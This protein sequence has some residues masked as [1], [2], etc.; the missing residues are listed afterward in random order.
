MSKL[1]GLPKKVQTAMG[2]ENLAKSENRGKTTGLPSGA[3]KI[4]LPPRTFLYTLDQISVMLDLPVRALKESHLYFEGRSTG[5]RKNDLM[6]CRNIAATGEKPEWRIAE[7]EFTRWMRTKGFRFYEN[8][9]F[10]N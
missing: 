1:T 7:R 5:S 4:G 6:T 8:S 9:G 2:N 3:K 10:S